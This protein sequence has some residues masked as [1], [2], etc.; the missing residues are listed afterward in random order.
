MPDDIQNQANNQ[1]VN[2][3]SFDKPESDKLLENVDEVKELEREIE[4]LKKQSEEYLDG[5]KRAKAEL[6][7]YKKED[8]ARLEEVARFGN[9]DLIRE[10]V[11]VLDSF[12]LGLITFEKEGLAS[13]GFY[14]IRSQLEDILKKR[15]LERIMVSVGQPFDPGLQESIAEI[16][17]NLPAGQVVEEVEKGYLLHGRVLR[18]ARVKVSVRKYEK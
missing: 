3:S 12:D 6:I 15:G 16:E 10:L 8:L 4:K 13:K 9:E 17:S 11:P 18:P 1:Q 2:Q 7:N 14:M 5:W